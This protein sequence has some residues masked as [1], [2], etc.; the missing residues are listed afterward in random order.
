MY[1]AARACFSV[2]SDIRLEA[3]PVRCA[4]C[5]NSRFTF[6]GSIS[7]QFPFHLHLGFVQTLYR[8]IGCSEFAQI[9][10][11]GPIRR[12]RRRE[13]FGGPSWQV[14]FLHQLKVYIFRLLFPITSFSYAPSRWCKHCTGRQVAPN[15]R[16][17]PYTALYGAAG[18]AAVWR[19]VPVRAP[20]APT[21]GLHFQALLSHRFL[22]ICTLVQ[23]K[24]CTGDRQLRI[25]ANFHSRPYTALQE[26]KQFGGLSRQMSTLH[27]TK[28][29][30]VRLLFPIAS[31][32]YAPS[33]GANTVPGDR[34]LRICANFHTR[35]YTALQET[36]QFGG[37]SRQMST[38]HQTKVYIVRLF[39]PK[40][41][42][43]Y[44]PFV[45]ASTAAGDKQLRIRTNF[46]TRHCTALQES[47]QFGGPSRQVR[48]KLVLF[49]LSTLLFSLVTV[50]F[51][52]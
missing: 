33:V 13:Q 22:F 47:Q 17:F 5:T 52:A 44:A 9:F 4:F 35:Y 26:M 43:S 25:C 42:F 14:R 30:I 49:Q 28:V 16:K 50:S 24:H 7:P 10:I 34:Q 46:H 1:A 39:F 40:T 27:Q 41:S 51:Q 2:H 6:L 15:L 38:L 36:K 11:H 48:F 19:P 8:A 31:F 3:R 21:Q 23:C 32:S 12:C 20:F 18:I 29:Y 37:P 45:G